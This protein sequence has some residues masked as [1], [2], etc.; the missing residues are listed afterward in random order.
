MQKIKANYGPKNKEKPLISVLMPTYNRA[1]YIAEALHSV[2]PQLS[3]NDEVIIIDDGS[4][5]NTCEVVKPFLK[6]KRI[7]Y[8]IKEH[9]NAPHTRNL[10]I[11]KSKNNWLLWLDSDDV[12][13]PGIVSLLKK[14]ITEFPDVSVFYGN[15]ILFGKIDKINRMKFKDYYNKNDELV[16]DMFTQ[17]RIPNPGTVVSKEI[18]KRFG[19]YDEKYLRLHD[20]ELWLRMLKDVKFKHVNRYVCKWRWH[21]KN[22]SSGSV[23]RDKRYD[24]KIV[25]EFLKRYSLS[26]I[27]YS[28]NWKKEKESLHK[29]F[30]CVGKNYSAKGVYIKANEYFLKSMGG[31][32]V[33]EVYNNIF[34]NLLKSGDLFHAILKSIPVIHK[35]KMIHCFAKSGK[36]LDMFYL[37]SFYKKSN[38]FKLSEKLFQKLLSKKS[39]YLKDKLLAGKACFHLGEIKISQN[40][41]R[42][43]LIHFNNAVKFYPD[44]LQAQSYINNLQ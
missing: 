34:M 13:L 4:M 1:E 36:N 23:V 14:H 41:K 18:Y 17:N 8:I 2:I 5:D 6:D 37:A 15:L 44:H 33:R 3:A 29:A 27:F 35:N 39:V 11:E 12:L 9:T 43:A 20:N 30:L 40:K 31:R 24:E 22:M 38:E 28:Y 7:Q 21:D 32:I 26:E 16:F 25:D 10:L 42:A 19:M